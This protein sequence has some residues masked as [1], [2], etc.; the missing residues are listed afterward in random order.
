[1]FDTECQKECFVCPGG[2]G[3]LGPEHSSD[4]TWKLV[5]R[6]LQLKITDSILMVVFSSTP[7]RSLTQ[8]PLIAKLLLAEVR[9]NNL[10]M[11]G[12]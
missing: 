9:C 1:M 7:S 11:V 12:F 6:I 4:Y 10:L 5:E 8:L 3:E 2:D